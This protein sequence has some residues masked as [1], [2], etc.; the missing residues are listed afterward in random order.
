MNLQ[1]EA[2]HHLKASSAAS[3]ELN[4]QLPQ[5]PF[6]APAQ[7]GFADGVKHRMGQ[8]AGAGPATAADQGLQVSSPLIRK[9]AQSGAG[10]P[11]KPLLTLSPNAV[12]RAQLMLSEVPVLL[13]LVTPVRIYMH[14]SACC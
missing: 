1:Q 7:P 14:I 13:T 2:E 12:Q 3:S 4:F 8:Q 11:S 6:A 9:A 10:E 5:Q